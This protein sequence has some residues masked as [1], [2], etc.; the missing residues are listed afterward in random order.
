MVMNGDLHPCAVCSFSSLVMWQQTR[1]PVG[2]ANTRFSSAGEG[3]SL[4]RAYEIA[5]VVEARKTIMHLGC[6]VT[7]LDDIIMSVDELMWRN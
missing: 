7:F 3:R 1:V 6:M 5:Q 4:G 2:H